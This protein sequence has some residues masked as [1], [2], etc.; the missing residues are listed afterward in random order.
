MNT[1]AVEARYR[2]Q[3]GHDPSDEQATGWKLTEFL[4]TMTSGAV[5]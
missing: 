2:E 3:M 1:A 4:N 5:A